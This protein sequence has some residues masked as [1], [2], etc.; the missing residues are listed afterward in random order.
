MISE[1][2][3]LGLDT[4]LDGT[5]NVLLERDQ[6]VADSLGGKA[7]KDWQP[8]ATVPCFL[9]RGTG[10]SVTRIG[11]LQEKPEQTVDLDIGGMVLPAGTD[12]TAGDR[13][14]Q[15][16]DQD[17]DVLEPGPIEILS[18]AAFTPLVELSFRRA[19]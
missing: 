11:G 15:V 16:V 13:I 7:A 18:V 14:A 5:Q 12:V 10:A 9:W 8:L 17:G 19:R 3:S 1:L 4:L 6:A 2:A